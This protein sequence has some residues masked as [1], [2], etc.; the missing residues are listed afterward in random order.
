M[1]GSNLDFL[2]EWFTFVVHLPFS[3]T[4]KKMPNKVMFYFEDQT[5]TFKQIDEY[6]NKVANYF[7]S[8]N[9]SKNDTIAL[10]M[11]NR[12][13]YYTIPTNNNCPYQLTKKWEIILLILRNLLVVWL[14][15][16]KK[17]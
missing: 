8:L 2:Y 3:K 1:E 11:E 10:F 14:Q 12:W 17:K 16:A 7:S 6:S 9:Y 4:A 5:W 13:I 15:F